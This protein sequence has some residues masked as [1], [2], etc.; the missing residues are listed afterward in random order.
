M[1]FSHAFNL[2]AVSQPSNH[3]S[4][5]L[6]LH[7]MSKTIHVDDTLMVLPQSPPFLLKLAGGTPGVGETA[8][9]P[10]PF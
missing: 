6:V 8:L 10:A 2:C 9:T 5:V 3:F 7:K 1:S 4:S